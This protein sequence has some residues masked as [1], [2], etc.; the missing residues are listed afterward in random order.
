MC[1]FLKGEV[2]INVLR[3]SNKTYAYSFVSFGVVTLRVFIAFSSRHGESFLGAFHVTKHQ[4]N[5]S[6]P[7]AQQPDA[8]TLVVGS[9]QQLPV[10]K[11]LRRKFGNE[12]MLQLQQK[13]W[14]CYDY[15]GGI[16]SKAINKVVLF[17]VNK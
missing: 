17:I 12:W 3:V 4:W 13:H 16:S 7:Y 9:S 1:V 15:S 8:S 11:M 5:M 2:I 14:L 6:A 10:V